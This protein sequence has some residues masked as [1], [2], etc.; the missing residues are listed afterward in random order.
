M[1]ERPELDDDLD[2]R[3]REEPPDRLLLEL[4]LFDFCANAN[5]LSR[6]G[7]LLINCSLLLCGA[8][9]G[10]REPVEEIALE[11]LALLIVHEAPV[12]VELEL[13]QLALDRV[14]VI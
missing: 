8:L 14:L 2:E 13:N 11:P 7:R 1:R 10:G 9:S 3:F 6:R 4:L 12:V 5:H